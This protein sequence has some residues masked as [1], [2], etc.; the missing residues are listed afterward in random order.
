MVLLN[1]VLWCWYWVAGKWMTGMKEDGTGGCGWSG[2]IK[3]RGL[4]Q[5]HT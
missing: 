4:F 3:I 2:Q 5:K 1:K